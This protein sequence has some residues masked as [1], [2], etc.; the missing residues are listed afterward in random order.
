ME[1]VTTLTRG[2]GFLPGPALVQKEELRD[3]WDG[4]TTGRDDLY[5]LSHTMNGLIM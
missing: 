3:G 4:G 5:I 1:E 2:L